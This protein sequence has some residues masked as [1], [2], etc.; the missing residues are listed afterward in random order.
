MDGNSG[1]SSGHSGVS[2]PTGVGV[3]A[4]LHPRVAP[5]LGPHRNGFGRGFSFAPMGDPTGTQ[6][7]PSNI[8]HPSLQ[9]PNPAR[10]LTHR[11]RPH[12]IFFDY[13]LSQI[14]SLFI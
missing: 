1:A 3:G 11:H 9:R 8:F 2:D 12:C 5:A 4:I 13:Y 14:F 7:K 6:K 10:I